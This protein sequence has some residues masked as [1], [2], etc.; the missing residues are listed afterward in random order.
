MARKAGGA[1]EHVQVTA[2][3]DGPQEVKL[4]PKDVSLDGSGVVRVVD[5]S[6]IRGDATSR[7]RVLTPEEEAALP[8]VK[9]YRV[10]R[11]G[12]ALMKSGSG[13]YRARLK[14]GKEID[15]LNYDVRDLQR[16]GIR[17]ERINPDMTDH[18]AFVD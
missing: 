17:V 1:D 2:V 5:A 11:G 18:E 12:M 15:S 9:R 4:E 6:P 14:E 7:N 8:E 10:T 13:G 16:Q 3:Y